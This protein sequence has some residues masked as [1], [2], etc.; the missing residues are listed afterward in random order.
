[1][2]ND[3]EGSAIS[4]GSFG[5]TGVRSSMNNFQNKWVFWVDLGRRRARARMLFYNH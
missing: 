1:M 5:L 2:R 3:G 4:D